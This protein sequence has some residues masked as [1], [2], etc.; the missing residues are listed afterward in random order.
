MADLLNEKMKLSHRLQGV[1][2]ALADEITEILSEA[3]DDVTGKILVL[4]A[5][6]EQTESLVR[7]KKYLE[8]QKAEIGRVLGEV[9][10]DIG[11]TIKD[12]AIET[13]Q[14]ALEIADAML[15][16]VIP[17]RFNIQL[18]VPHLD[19]KRVIAWFESSQIDGLFFND[20]LKKLEEN[21]AAR[22]IRES[23]L[24]MISGD[25]RRLAAKRIQKAL[26]TGRKSAGG[27]AQNA[28]RQAYNWAERE[29]LIENEQMLRGLRF[30]AE[31]D[32]RTTPICRSLD[33]KVF[34][35][36]DC[37]LPPLHWRCRSSIEPVFKNVQLE[38]YLAREEKSIRIARIDTKPRTV[39]HRDG[40][41]STKYEKLRVKFPPARQNYNQWMT[42]MV[43]SS[44]PADVA[45]AKEVLGPAR[46]D[47]VKS[48][49]LKMNQLYYAGK[50]RTIKQLKELM[51]Q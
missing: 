22:I 41:T 20:W 23:R 11:Q 36:A 17:A 18:G 45:F 30:I 5:K 31:L 29:Y 38:R 51:K 15:S 28:I 32:R 14:A 3:A 19:K 43:K 25:D 27:L 33:G 1:V 16:K 4:E 2:N 40:T 37:P 48:D 26:N 39:H 34:K 47:L 12:R 50:L 46:F 21:A 35:I 9:Y 42:S 7:R 44:N 10:Q 13:G 49:K 6:A 24:A 8:K